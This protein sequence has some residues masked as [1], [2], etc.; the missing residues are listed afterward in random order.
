M[1]C[2][3]K[4]MLMLLAVVITQVVWNIGKVDCPINVSIFL[5]NEYR[6]IYTLKY[7]IT[8]KQT[9]KFF[10]IAINILLFCPR[11]ER[12]ILQCKPRRI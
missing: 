2:W 6:I 1:Y 10:L 8:E 11:K 7:Y 3:R 9:L 4:E 5:K 12:S